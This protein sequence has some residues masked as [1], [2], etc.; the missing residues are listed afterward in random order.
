MITGSS[1]LEMCAGLR[2]LGGA[3]DLDHVAVGLRHAVQ[4]ARRRGDQVHVELALEPLLHDLHVQQPEEAAAEA[5][6]Q[7]HRGFRLEEERGVIQSQLLERLAQLRV[8]MAL[9]RVEPGEHHRLQLLEAGERLG[10]RPVGLG[11]GIADLRVGHDLDAARDEADFARLRAVPPG[12]P[13][14]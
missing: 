3:V 13:S 8:L 6:A 12:S 1:I 5:E 11:D 2:Q 14:A 7:R 4:H 9:H 10:R